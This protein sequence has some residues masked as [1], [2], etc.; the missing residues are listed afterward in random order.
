MN[1]LKN[2]HAALF[3]C[4]CAMAMSPATL[5]SALP[6]AIFN[7]GVD[8][9]SNAWGTGGVTD[10]HYSLLS[11]P[12]PG[13]LTALTVTD[14]AFP[15]PPGG[16]PW[17]VNNAG[18]RW[19]GPG[20][21]NQPPFD[22]TGPAGNYIY[23]TTFNVPA[24]ALLSSVSITG[25][26]AVDDNGTDILI[27]GASTG[28]SILGYSLNPFSVNSGF[29]FGTNTLDFLVFNGGGSPN[30]TGLRVDHIAGTYQQVPEPGTAVL[31]GAA[32]TFSM[33]ALRRSR[34]LQV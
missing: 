21:P 18:S 13:G 9:L 17:V 7:T 34:R 33:V 28:Q 14:T 8:T 24:N 2:R 23:R 6:I 16:G 1:A 20:T 31:I 15:F 12:S 3:W 10:I 29:A 32:I 30:W 26:W 25:D 5:C 19:I 4:A 22:G 27:N 11:Q